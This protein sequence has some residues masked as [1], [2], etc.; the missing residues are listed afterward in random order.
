MDL[1]V[2]L[3]ITGFVYG[4]SDKKTNP[5]LFK[6]STSPTKEKS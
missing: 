4:S 2:R 5:P 3:E 1:V 6:Q